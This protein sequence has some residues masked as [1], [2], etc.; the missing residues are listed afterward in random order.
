MKV[1]HSRT[2][3][4]RKVC[5][6]SIF[7]MLTKQTEQNSHVCPDI[8][9]AH[10]ILV[11]MPRQTVKRSILFT[12]G[13]NNHRSVRQSRVYLFCEGEN[14]LGQKRGFIAQDG[15]WLLIG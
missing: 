15:C 9:N 5:L 2:V 14:S 3:H 1:M 8:G 7:T 6:P 12:E 13:S 10:V 11:Y 4:R